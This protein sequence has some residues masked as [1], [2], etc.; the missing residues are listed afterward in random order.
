M[1]AQLMLDRANILLQQSRFADAETHIR[2]ALEQEPRNDHAL[3]L[4]S[5]C[6]LSTQQYQ[7]AI[8]AIK[9]AISIAPNDS[10]YFYLLG[11]AQYKINQNLAAIATLNRAI[12][13]NPYAGEYF[14][15]LA[16]L[17]IEERKFEEA[18]SK[19]NEGLSLEA[20]N[21]TCLN[22]RATA[23]NKLRR[24]ND[25]IDTMNTAL[26]QDPDNEVT[27]NTVG[28]NLLERGRN[29]DAQ[30]HFME[31]L[32]INPNFT[33]ARS[34]L[35]ESLKSKLLLYKWLLQY[36][37][38]LH[39]Q[40][41]RMRIALPIALYIV[42]R[43][44]IALTDGNENTEGIA[45][46]LGAIYLLFVFTSWTIGSIANCVLLFHPLGKHSLS[47]TEKWGAIN[48]VSVLLAGIAMISLSGLTIGTDYE[49]G[50]IPMG[51]IFISLAL[52]LGRIEY[53]ISFQNKTW[54]QKYAVA[55]MAFALITLLVFSIA[56]SAIITL[57]LIYIVAFI[58]Y[59][60]SGALS[61]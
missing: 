55:L 32:R 21:L 56:P 60:W 5:R 11:F 45:W 48:S 53:P 61:A 42:F 31:A 29:K 43:T 39:N 27:H 22:A 57:F 6:Y 8:D 19:A 52:P 7:K 16:F 51:I 4:L 3:S 34:G 36:S 37:F 25:A 58:V 49:A 10:F 12:E 23:L 33:G 40:G 20:D 15:L 14:G 41:K 44:L 26:A 28:W 59:N 17:F 9:D 1:E 18:L 35:K 13:L 54:K 46:I 2:Q 50:M 38:W 47:N 24:T 30:N